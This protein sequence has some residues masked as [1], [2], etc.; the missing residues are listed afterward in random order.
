MSNTYTAETL[1]HLADLEAGP[2]CEDPAYVEVRRRLAACWNACDGFTTIEL[3]CLRLP[4]RQLMRIDE[5]ATARAERDALQA[6]IDAVT[7]ALGNQ[8]LQHFIEKHGE[9]VPIVAQ[10]DELAAVLSEMV[11]MMN[12]NEEH[13]AG[14]PWHQRATAALAFL[15][16]KPT[17]PRITVT[18]VC[19]T[20][21]EKCNFVDTQPCGSRCTTCGV[22]IP[23]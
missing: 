23:F 21:E 15:Q 7:K 10:R 20:N 12:K 13:G 19:G 11:T 8:Q 4:L 16:P 6:T 14:S 3:E 22:T 5:L 1:L 17:A 9:P 18:N 2:N